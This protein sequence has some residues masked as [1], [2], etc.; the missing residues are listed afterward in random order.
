M[1]SLGRSG[2]IIA[3]L[4][5][6]AAIAGGIYWIF[7]PKQNGLK[8]SSGSDAGLI[9]PSLKLDDLVLEQAGDDG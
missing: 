3:G 4:V 9:D 2:Q 7:Q 8:S 6:L 1:K 5:L